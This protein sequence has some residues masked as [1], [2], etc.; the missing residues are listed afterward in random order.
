MNDNDR[1]TLGDLISA[2]RPDGDSIRVSK[3]DLD[4]PLAEVFGLRPGDTISTAGGKVQVIR[5]NGETQGVE[6]AHGG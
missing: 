4:R 3:A 1:I 5:A 2:T 6:V